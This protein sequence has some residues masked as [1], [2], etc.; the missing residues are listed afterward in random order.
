M[1]LPSNTD[2]NCTHIRGVLGHLGC[3]DLQGEGTSKGS[4]ECEGCG[5]TYDMH[6][7]LVNSPWPLAHDLVKVWWYRG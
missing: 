7:H 2:Q 6:S 1:V 3:G 5:D 4:R